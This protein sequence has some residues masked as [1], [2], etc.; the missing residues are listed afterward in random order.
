[1]HPLRYCAVRF[2]KLISL[3]IMGS[4]FDKFEDNL[5]KM[6]F[7][8]E[9]KGDS[10]LIWREIVFLILIAAIAF[11]LAG[12]VYMQTN[13]YA[14]KEQRFARLIALSIDSA[15]PVTL[16]NFYAKGFYNVWID[17]EK[18][19]IYVKYPDNSPGRSYQYFNNN[20]VD[21]EFSNSIVK[22]EVT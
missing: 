9:K 15:K 11:I 8:K 6:W 21:L 5:K 3:W 19:T 10:E 16:I 20:K 22:I 7:L 12:F 17:K 14:L 2:I 1:M 18:K 4:S 13:G